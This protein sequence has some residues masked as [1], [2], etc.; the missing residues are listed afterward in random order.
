MTKWL[1]IIA[2]LALLAGVLTLPTTGCSGGGKATE[3]DNPEEA[4]PAGHEDAAKA[5]DQNKKPEGQK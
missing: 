4:P 5:I 1:R 3:L 2:A